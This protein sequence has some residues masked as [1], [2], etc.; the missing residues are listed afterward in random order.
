MKAV[1]IVQAR[2]GSTRLPGK[3][4]QT[5]SGKTVLGHVIRRVRSCPLIETVVIAT[6]DK[7]IDDDIVTE[8]RKHGAD[9]FRGSE[10]DVLSRYY[11]AAVAQSAQHVVR[12]ELMQAM[13]RY[14]AVAAIGIVLDVKTGE[15]VAMSSVPDYDANNRDEALQPEKM[16][17]ATVGVFEMG[18][19]FKGFTTAMALDSGR[20]SITDSFDATHGLTVGK[21][22]ISDFHGK[23]RILTVPEIFIY[24]S[25]VGSGR[26]ALAVGME[27][28]H[29]YLKRFGLLDTL[30]TELP[31]TGAPIVPPMPWAK[32]TTVT[33]AF[34]H[35]ISVSPMQTAAAAAALVN[36]GYFVTPTFLPRSIEETARIAGITSKPPCVDPFG[37]STH[38]GCCASPVNWIVSPKWR[39]SFRVATVCEESIRFSTER[40]RFRISFW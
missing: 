2:M 39:A 6:T 14:H 26:E 1:A 9:T 16:N 11:H 24:S 20:V 10:D 17:R 25:N 27:W 18:S 12:D 33:M 36:G 38:W 13:E 37:N 30:K 4:L 21:F 28:Q 15:V 3:V 29:E 40:S 35:G 34:G 5:L 8:A 22:T 23:H 31:E 19:T 32:V 7:A